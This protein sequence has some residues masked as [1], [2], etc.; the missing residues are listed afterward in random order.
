M[1][2]IRL[3][4][5][6]TRDVT[7]DELDPET[8]ATIRPEDLAALRAEWLPRMA[9]TIEPGVA[10]TVDGGAPVSCG[11][12]LRAWADRMAAAHGPTIIVWRTP[13]PWLAALAVVLYGEAPAWPQTDGTWQR[14]WPGE[15]TPA[16]VDRA[17]RWEAGTDIPAAVS[18]RAVV[19]P[20]SR[21][22]VVKAD[23]T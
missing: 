23:L 4:S 21:L 13:L 7:L 3:P 8:I 2:L 19:M 10:I 18:G 14:K 1:P 11:A 12:A 15:W 22:S 5:V 17:L 9:E 20:G 16:A 6:Q